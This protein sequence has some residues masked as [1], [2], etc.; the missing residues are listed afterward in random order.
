MDKLTVGMATFDDFD[1]TVFT[2][3]DLHL[4]HS[5]D[6]G[7]VII[8][9]NNP[10]SQ[11]GHMVREFIHNAFGDNGWAEYV[12]FPT[13]KGT[14]VPRNMVFERAPAGIVVC[15]DSHVLFYPGALS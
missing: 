15:T 7:K 14:A 1:G 2:V 4:H 13:P 9:D 6:V 10:D 5:G 12:A 8:I 11:H 3:K